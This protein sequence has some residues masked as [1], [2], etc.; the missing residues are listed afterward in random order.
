MK[1]KKSSPRLTIA[2]KAY[3]AGIVDGEGCIGIHKN[4]RKSCKKG[5]CYRANI[6]IGVTDKKF[7]NWLFKK[8][9]LGTINNKGLK[10]NR[11]KIVYCLS[12][13][14]KD[15]LILLE[16]IKKYLIIKKKQAKILLKFINNK[17]Y[18]NRLTDEE[19]LFQDKCY[20][21][22]KKLNQRGT[23]V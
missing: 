18:C 6:Q 8:I 13:C 12:L 3:I 15:S 21:Q 11:W 19:S 2:E 17:K 7:I 16:L 1:T 14:A 10:I 9:K 22:M 20:Q 5:F 23:N 4:A